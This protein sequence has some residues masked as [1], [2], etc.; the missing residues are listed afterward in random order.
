MK[1]RPGSIL[2]VLLCISLVTTPLTSMSSATEVK[3]AP[4]PQN[5]G[6]QIALQ[7][8]EDIAAS[9][10][11]ILKKV[12]SKILNEIDATKTASARAAIE[13]QLKNT[14]NNPQAVE[15]LREQARVTAV[16]EA[17]RARDD[18]L[19]KLKKASVEALDRYGKELSKNK[20]YASFA[21]EYAAAYTRTEKVKVLNQVVVQDMNQVLQVTLKRL[22]WLTAE[23]LRTDLK[24]LENRVFG[25]KDDS[26]KVKRILLIAGAVVAFIGLVTW[27]VTAGKYSKIR[28]DRRSELENQYQKLRSAHLKERDALAATQK[29]EL[30]ALV[31]KLTADYNHLNETLTAQELDFLHNNGY[32]WMQCNSYQQVSSIICNKYN[33]QVF[34]GTTTCTVMCYKNVLQNKETLH[35]APVCSSPYIPADCFSQTMYNAEYNAGYHDGYQDYYPD[36]EADGRHDGAIDGHDDGAEDGD[37]DGY[38]DGYDDGYYDGYD[39]EYGRAYI[40]GYTDRYDNGYT[41]GY[42]DGWDDGYADGYEDGQGLMEGSSFQ[43]LASLFSTSAQSLIHGSFFNKGYKD[44]YRDAHA[45]KSYQ[46]GTKAAKAI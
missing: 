32:T 39:Y 41:D 5:S 30:D 6:K 31:A 13:E 4:K 35:A 24:Q 15:E 18:L 29:A 7:M 21:Q 25:G 9:T 3:E 8:L 23:G 10:A 14:E 16:S 2:S 37:E 12:D 17:L 42:N 38:N 40:D 26:G 43:G 46:S 27:G 19:N 34:S 11:K 20:A 44:G 1:F 33:Y 28:D 36:G 22:N 45:M